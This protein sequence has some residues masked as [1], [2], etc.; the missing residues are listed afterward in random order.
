MINFEPLGLCHYKRLK[1]YFANQ[2]YQLSGY[3]LTSLIVWQQPKPYFAIRENTVIMY[4]ESERHPEDKYLVLP[5]SVDGEFSPPMLYDLTQET[6]IPRYWFVPEDYL[7]RQSMA[8]ID[9][10]FHCEEQPLFE[11]YVYLASDL[12][13]LKGNKYSKKRNLINQF[14][15]NH[16]D[17]GRVSVGTITPQNAEECLAF[18]E[19]WCDEYALETPPDEDFMCEKEAVTNTIKNIDT[20]DV[21]SHVIGIDGAV[22]A[23]GVC[24][25]LNAETVVLNFEKAYS[26]VK[27]LYQYLDQECAKL[28]YKRYKYI[29]KESDMGIPGLTHAKKSYYPVKRIKSYRLT[30]KG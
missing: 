19:K 12:A 11:D 14:L 24:S 10:L 8:E 18:L 6:G 20:F 9:S 25:H 1:P 29:N 3:S 17:S 26:G 7:K 30:I 23:F 13:E 28:I 16:G 27:G 22:S 15:R 5:V 4:A 2:H 21:K